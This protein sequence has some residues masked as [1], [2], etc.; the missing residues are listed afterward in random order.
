MVREYLQGPMS[1]MLDLRDHA[2]ARDYDED[3]EAW[4]L[5]WHCESIG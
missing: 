5:A 3:N 2:F 1:D 4:G